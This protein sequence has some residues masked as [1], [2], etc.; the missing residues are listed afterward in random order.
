[1]RIGIDIGS[2]VDARLENL[3]FE[4]VQHNSISLFVL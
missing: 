2:S 3:E 4:G 1:M